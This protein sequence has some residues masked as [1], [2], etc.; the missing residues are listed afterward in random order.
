M[1]QIYFLQLQK[2]NTVFHVQGISNR[3]T[4]ETTI[5]H[6]MHSSLVIIDELGRG[7]STYDG[8]G[9]AWSI[10]DYLINNIKCFCLFATHYHELTTLETKME[11]VRNL[12]VSAHTTDHTITM[13]YNVRDNFS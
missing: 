10:S 6:P 12:H 1:L 11:S 4:N 9:L 5:F 13:L 8:F 3:I 2:G 7:T